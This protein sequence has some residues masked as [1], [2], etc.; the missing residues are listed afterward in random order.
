M[1]KFE[2]ISFS[3]DYS[4]SDSDSEYDEGTATMNYIHKLTDDSLKVETKVS[5]IENNYI[6]IGAETTKEAYKR[7]YPSTGIRKYD[8]EASSNAYYIQDEIDLSDFILTLGA[9]LD[10]HEK[11]GTEVSP[12]LGLVYKLSENQ[13]LK[14]SYGEGFKA[15]S[16]QEASSEYNTYSHGQYYGND[17]LKSETSKSYEIGYEYYGKNTL[18]K[19]A[20]FS[21]KLD[22][23]INGEFIGVGYPYASGFAVNEYKYV[24]IEKATIKGFEAEVDYNLN[25]NHILNANY[26][27]LKTEDEST[28]KELLFKPKNTINVS[29]SSE[30]NHGFSSYIS[31]NYI[32]TQYDTNEKSF[33][34]YFG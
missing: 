6:V 4:K 23:M 32:G 13:R 7:D 8:F 16:L 19:T 5:M 30:F 25:E 14:A 10:D 11:Y 27:Y 15:P 33:W 29:L 22:N 9:R 12:N 2:D 28:G 17:D 1:K 20:I 24:N 18:Y 31:A 26:T 21:T 3:I 34:L